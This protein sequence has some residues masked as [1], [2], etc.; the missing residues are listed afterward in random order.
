[1]DQY[2]GTIIN[3]GE[4]TIFLRRL[5]N[6]PPLLLLHGFPETHLM[7]R[8]IAPLLADHFTVV[9]ADLRGYGQSGCPKSDTLHFPYSKRAMAKD[10]VIV[11]ER[12]GFTDF[13]LA[14]HDRGARVAY[15]LALDFSD[16]V[17]KVCV[18]D[19]IP[20][21][22]A[23]KR[24]DKQFVLDFWPWSLLAQTTP[25]PEQLITAAPEAIINNIM[26][27]WGTPETTFSPEIKEAYAIQLGDHKHIH[28]I[29]EEYRAAAT[30]DIAHDT[31]DQKNGRKIQCPVQVLWAADGPLDTWYK[32]EGGPLEI[33]RKWSNEVSG[34]SI[35]GGH[36]FPEE[37]PGPIAESFISFF[38]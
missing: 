12:L 20:G 36:F 10:M 13:Y 34:N 26:T 1:M 25:F 15:R 28:A 6:G 11:M 16:Q 29:C 37:L 35:K 19:I 27:D 2:E 22:E 14:G 32:N 3:T 24:A 18:L 8:D 23:W 9:C 21:M 38:R 31:E 17:K 33:W 5:G 30:I 4:T 7:W